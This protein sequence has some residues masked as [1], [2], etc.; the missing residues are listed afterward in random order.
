MHIVSINV[1]KVAPL[2]AEA[3]G[4][5]ARVLSAIYKTS[6]SSA[7]DPRSVE[8]GWLGLKGDEQAD[9]SVHGGRDKALYAYPVEHYPVWRTIRMQALKLDEALPFG[10][11]GENLSI[12]G[13]LETALWIGDVISIGESGSGQVIARVAAPRAP[14]FKFNARMG[15][16]QA[17]QMMVQSGYTGFYLEV[18]QTGSLRAGDPLRV[19][20]GARL[21]RVDEMHR[22]NTRGQQRALI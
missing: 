2:F 13:L 22:L 21:V 1:G 10:A 15:F 3:E 17:A 4:A 14:C 18:M 6:I 7:E 20:P 16:K 8:V 12:H 19:A 5:R 11:M 9:P